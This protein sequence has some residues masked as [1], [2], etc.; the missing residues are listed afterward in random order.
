MGK[1][2]LSSKELRQFPTI[3]SLSDLCGEHDPREWGLCRKGDKVVFGE[4]NEGRVLQVSLN[5]LYERAHYAFGGE[6]NPNKVIIFY[7]VETGVNYMEC[8]LHELTSDDCI[9]QT[10][11]YPTIKGVTYN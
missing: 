11:P 7:A 1:T 9:I 10:L 8:F 4:A 5:E 2:Y 6:Y 3:G